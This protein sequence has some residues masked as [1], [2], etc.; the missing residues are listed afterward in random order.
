MRPKQHWE[1]IYT[2]KSTDR[3]SWFQKHAEQSLRLIRETGVAEDATII[4]V[5][6]GAS[7]LVDDLLASGYSALTVLDPAAAALAASKQRLGSRA[8]EVRW[9]EADVTTAT[10]PMHGYDVW[11]DRAVFHFLTSAEQ[12]MAYVRAVLHAVRPGGHIIVAMFA[13]DGPT[14]CSGLPVMRYSADQ[15][16]AEFGQHF[17]LL[18]HAKEEHKTP[19]GTAQKFVYC[20]YRRVSTCTAEVNSDEPTSSLRSRQTR[21]TR[22]SLAAAAPWGSH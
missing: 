15:L 4:D 1:H 14:E 19:I 5:G 18:K 3:V 6:G 22:Q 21:S 13:E 9:L 7:T 20:Y 11:H 10:L 17:Q 2:T 8:G 12:R 16:H